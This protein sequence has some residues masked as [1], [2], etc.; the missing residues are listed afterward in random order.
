MADPFKNRISPRE[1]KASK[2]FAAPSKEQATTGRFMPPGDDYGIGF[3]QNV[4][5]EQASGLRA[6]AIPQEC[7]CIDP[8][9]V[10]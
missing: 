7:K 9:S 4:G 1:R 5:K 8:N 3:R 6:G 10:A 2:N